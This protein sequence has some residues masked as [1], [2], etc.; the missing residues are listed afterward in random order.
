[1]NS[2]GVIKLRLNRN[3]NFATFFMSI[4]VDL[5][6]RRSDET[7]SERKSDT[8][9]SDR[10][11]IM[12]SRG[13]A[14]NQASSSL[15]RTILVGPE[16]VIAVHLLAQFRTLNVGVWVDF[17]ASFLSFIGSSGHAYAVGHAKGQPSHRCRT[18]LQHG[19]AG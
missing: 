4:G 18:G 13:T 6:K 2:E 1:M 7:K 19:F 14:S 12:L 9:F 15:K 16:D 5:H 3:S 10:N 17:S 8:V 11:A